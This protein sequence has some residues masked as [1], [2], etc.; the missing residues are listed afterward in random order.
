MSFC[1][2]QKLNIILDGQFGST[3]KGLISGYLSLTEDFDIF[4][5]NLSPNAGHTFYNSN[6]ERFMTKQLPIGGILNK[7]SMIYL[8]PGSIID[9]QIL[10][11]EIDDYNIDSTRLFIHPRCAV[12][13]KKHIMKEKDSNSSVSKIASTQSGTGEALSDKVLRKSPVAKDISELQ[14]FIK[15]IDLMELM[16][17][18]CNILMETSQGFDLSIN[19]GYSY[20]HCTS[21]EVTTMSA[22]TDSQ[23]HPQY[24]GNVMMCIRTY[25]IRVGH[26]YKNGVKIGDSG[27]FYLDS[28]ETDWKTLGLDDEYTTVTQRV[29]RV[30]TFS[31]YQYKRAL[32]Y[33]K[34][35]HVFLNFVNQVSDDEYKEELFNIFKNTKYPTHLSYGKSVEDVVET[36]TRSRL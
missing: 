3:G 11:K 17:L 35:S 19:S 32:N 31:E 5:S 36:Q 16:D 6:N 15:D 20:P 4:C 2:S 12:V 18:G 29:R 27:P 26:T 23:V 33:I 7:R 9:P 24:L 10:L 30:A 8:T 34:P 13:Q 1:K 21:R 25:P 22:L 28:E 14:P